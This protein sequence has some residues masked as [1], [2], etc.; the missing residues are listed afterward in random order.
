MHEP[1]RILHVI[2]IMN[3]GGAETMIMNL[4]RSIDRSKVQFDFVENDNNGEQAAF[5]AEIES[6]GGRIFHC[7]KFTVRNYFQY[8]NWWKQ[9]LDGKG[10]QYLIVHGHI[11]S[12]AAIYL[13]EAKKRGI[14]T[15]AHSHGMNG[16][17]SLHNLGYS[18]FS[19]PTRFIA[20]VFFGCSIK[21]GIDRYGKKIVGNKSKYVSFNNAI[22]TSKF[23]YAPDIRQS[24]RKQLDVGN[25]QFV[26]GHVGRMD[27][28]K[29]QGFLLEVF[30]D[31]RNIHRDA[32]LLLVGEGVL[33]PELEEKAKLLGLEDSVAFLGIRSDVSELMQAMD[34]LVFPSK[35]E[36]LPITLVEAQTAGLPCVIS[37]RVPLDAIITSDLVS[38]MKLTDS[39]KAWAEH[40]LLRMNEERQDHSAEV[41]AAGFDIAKT[42]KWLEEFYVEK[43]K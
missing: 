37:D 18:L 16:N 31:F 29:N 24:Y 5:D 10:K 12:T 42:A 20:D 9:F 6:L 40:I 7:P 2:G 21:A 33:K 22:D 36:G 17:I 43:I 23:K 15:I 4:Y 38:V 11:G 25:D 34:M 8:K 27:D 19:Y 32:K 1:I 3:R 13:N 14:Y 35:N 26:I 30:S 28:A 41:A 39:P